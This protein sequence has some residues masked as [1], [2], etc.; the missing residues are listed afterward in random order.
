MSGYRLEQG[1]ITERYLAANNDDR[2]PVIHL[3][4]DGLIAEQRE[5]DI[6]EHKLRNFIDDGRSKPKGESDPPLWRV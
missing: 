1:P 2:R 3:S 6:A 4:N 5:S